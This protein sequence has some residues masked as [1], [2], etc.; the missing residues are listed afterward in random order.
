MNTETG[1]IICK[2]Q[3]AFNI[4]TSVTSSKG[5][6]L[7]ERSA[8]LSVSDWPQVVGKDGLSSFTGLGRQD[9][10]PPSIEH[11]SIDHLEGRLHLAN[12]VGKSRGCANGPQP[13]R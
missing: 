4:G 1:P 8:R 9:Q 7:V 6:L 10:L 13:L 2:R 5:A 11:T 3:N 12:Y